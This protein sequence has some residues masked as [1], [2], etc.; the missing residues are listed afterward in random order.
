M[1]VVAERWG[2]VYI[3][4]YLL[5]EGGV[6]LCQCGTVHVG[7]AV[8]STTEWQVD[9]IVSPFGLLYQSAGQGSPYVH[10]LLAPGGCL[11]EGHPLLLLYW[12]NPV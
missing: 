1:W 11:P 12:M 7:V 3:V 10:V 4:A 9:R 6:A 8:Q 5:G 2:Y